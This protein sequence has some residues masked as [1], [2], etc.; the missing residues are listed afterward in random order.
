MDPSASYVPGTVSSASARK[1]SASA[2]RP[3]SVAP[4]STGRARLQARGHPAGGHQRRMDNGRRCEGAAELSERRRAARFSWRGDSVFIYR[5]RRARHPDR[6]VV[7][8]R[9]GA[10]WRASRAGRP[11]GE[12]ASAW[13]P[14][15]GAQQLRQPARLRG[16]PGLRRTPTLRRRSASISRWRSGVHGQG[17]GRRPFRCTSSQPVARRCGAVRGLSA[18]K[19]SVARSSATSHRPAAPPHLD[20]PERHSIWL[21]DGEDGWLP[22]GECGP[23]SVNTFGNLSATER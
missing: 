15:G 11:S 23:S 2:T 1:P 7:S 6:R 21:S 8:A 19:C 18:L 9:Q 5:V 22:I 10:K 20:H 13:T 14:P 12:L 17:W 3:M 16:Q 4:G